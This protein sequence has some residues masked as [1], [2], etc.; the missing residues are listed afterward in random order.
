MFPLSSTFCSLG[1]FVARRRVG[2]RSRNNTKTRGWRDVVES[3]VLGYVCWTPRLIVPSTGFI[4][5]LCVPIP[6]LL[7]AVMGPAPDS[8]QLPCEGCSPTPQEGK[9]RPGEVTWLL[10]VRKDHGCPAALLTPPGPSACH[11]FSGAATP[12]WIYTH[13]TPHPLCHNIT[14]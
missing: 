6:P 2:G 3:Q 14:S 13:H 9:L 8:F 12:C 4:I 1:G 5:G 10:P 11:A 7:R